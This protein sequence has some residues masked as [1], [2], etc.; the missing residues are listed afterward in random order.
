MFHEPPT[1]AQ[2]AERLG[3]DPSDARLPGIREAALLV[4]SRVCEVDPFD[5][6]L[7]EAALRRAAFLFSSM[8]H[9]LGVLD[10][11]TD[12]GVQYLP[13]YHPDWDA[14]EVGRRKIVVA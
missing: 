3:L 10:T 13:L 5:A 8:P 1:E 11:G 14:L 6:G 2:V 9:T 12:Y 7:Y 4:Q